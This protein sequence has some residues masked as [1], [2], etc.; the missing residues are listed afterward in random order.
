MLLG[1]ALWMQTVWHWSALQTGLAIPPGPFLVP[2]TALLVAGRLI[3]RFGPAAVVTAG[4]LCFASGL[5]V[6]G[7]MTTLTPSAA[8][9]VG[10]MILTGIGVGLTFPTV[11]GVGT[12][13]LPASSFATGSGVLNMVRQASL[14]IGVALFVAIIGAPMS[15]AEQTAAFHRGWFLMAAI[16]LLGLVPTLL[17]IR[18][19]P[20]TAAPA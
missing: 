14:A 2:V 15:P 10:G 11:M 20:T 19:R 16:A 7:T 4:I 17:F 6:W 13:A 9:V 12:A 18:Q 1:L 8:V 5:L 3:A